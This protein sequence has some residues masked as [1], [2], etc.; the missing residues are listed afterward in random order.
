MTPAPSRPGA[1]MRAAAA[2][3]V[4]APGDRDSAFREGDR[5]AVNPALWCGACEH[6]IAGQESLCVD[7]RILGDEVPG[8]FAEYVCVP[9]RNLLRMPEDFPFEEA[10][11]CPLA[12]QT[13]WRGR[14]SS[15]SP[16]APRRR[17]PPSR[18]GRIS[19]P[20]PCG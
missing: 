1:T 4:A 6:C 20:R 2:G 13:A 18:S 8:G 19:P 17:R 9:A 3:V 10:A 7:F 12:F 15:R 5:V 16:P 11:A 14:A